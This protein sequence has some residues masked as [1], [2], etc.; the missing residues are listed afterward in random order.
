MDTIAAI[1]LRKRIISKPRSGI[2]VTKYIS[3]TG[4]ENDDCYQSPLD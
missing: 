2:C 1:N 3:R 4:G